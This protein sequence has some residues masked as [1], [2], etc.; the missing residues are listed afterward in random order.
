MSLLVPCL[1]II[2]R[3]K[4]MANPHITPTLAVCVKKTRRPIQAMLYIRT[5]PL[6]K[7]VRCTR[8]PSKFDTPQRKYK[9]YAHQHSPAAMT[10]RCRAIRAR[11]PI[12]SI[13]VLETPCG[14]TPASYSAASRSVYSTSR[15]STHPLRAC[16]WALHE[17]KYSLPPSA[18]KMTLT[19]DNVCALG[20]TLSFTPCCSSAGADANKNCPVVAAVVAMPEPVRIFSRCTVDVGGDRRCPFTDKGCRTKDRQCL[21]WEEKVSKLAKTSKPRLQAA[22]ILVLHS[23]C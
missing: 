2:L 10:L 13:L 14:L 6:R 21:G 20:A 9:L 7:G 19:S 8:H 5:Y 23:I 17:S 11:L 3:A 12:H 15:I 22:S 1:T 16:V 18:L 4:M